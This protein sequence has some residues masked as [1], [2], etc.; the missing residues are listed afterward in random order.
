M[1]ILFLVKLVFFVQNQEKIK[2]YFSKTSL[3][4]KFLLRKTLCVIT[5][6]IIFSSEAINYKGTAASILEVIAVTVS[7]LGREEGCTVKYTPPP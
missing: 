6:A 7:V 1:T 4:E 3:T 5:A 2:K